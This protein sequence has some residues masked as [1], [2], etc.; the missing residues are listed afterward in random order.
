MSKP[1]RQDPAVRAKKAERRKIRK[2]QEAAGVELLPR[3]A[4]PSAQMDHGTNPK[5][6][7]HAREGERA[8]ERERGQAR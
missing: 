2:A 1:R 7:R 5:G 6:A 3:R 4:R 8:I